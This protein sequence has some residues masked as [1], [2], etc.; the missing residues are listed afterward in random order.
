MKLVLREIALPMRR[1]FRIAHGETVVQT[2]LLVEL[3]DGHL[4]GYGEGAS[5]DYYGITARS[6]REALEAVR[7]EIEGARWDRPEELWEQMAPK[8]NQNRFS[9]CALDEAAY[10]LWG[11][12][13][14]N[15]STSFSDWSSSVF[16][17]AITRSG[18]IPS[19]KW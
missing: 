5:L 15:R 14:A 19:K 8:L 2:N 3:H 10:D 13:W 12:S 1:I 4:R 7:A 6:M 9:L 16:R 17:S 18:S 11:K